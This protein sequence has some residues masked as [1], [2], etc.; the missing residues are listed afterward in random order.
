M[1]NLGEQLT[2]ILYIESQTTYF[3]L[4]KNDEHI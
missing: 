3:F 4:G 1:R 2:L